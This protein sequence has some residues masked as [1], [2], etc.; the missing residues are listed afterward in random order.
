MEGSDIVINKKLFGIDLVEETMTIGGRTLDAGN[1]YS[2]LTLPP[3]TV[4]TLSR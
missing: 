3:W 4:R 1:I 2:P